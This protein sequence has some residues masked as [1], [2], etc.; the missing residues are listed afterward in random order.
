MASLPIRITV[1]QTAD[2]PWLNSNEPAIAARLDVT[3]HPAEDISKFQAALNESG[4]VTKLHSTNSN[5]YVVVDSESESFLLVNRI[6]HIP[7]VDGKG[8]H[9]HSYR[10]FDSN[11]PLQR[12]DA[13]FRDLHPNAEVG[14]RAENPA[15]MK[16]LQKLFHSLGYH[17]ND[18]VD[19]KL[20][21]LASPSNA[22][23]FQDVGAIKG[24]YDLTLKPLVADSGAELARDGNAKNPAYTQSPTE[25]ESYYK[26]FHA[27][28]M[29]SS[30]TMT[31]RFVIRG[32]YTPG[33][34][35]ALIITADA[36]L[37]ASPAIE[38]GEYAD[39]ALLALN[40]TARVATELIVTAGCAAE[41]AVEAAPLYL[42]P[43]VYAGAVVTGAAFCGSDMHH[44]LAIG[45][46]GLAII[47]ERVRDVADIK[48]LDP[49]HIWSSMLEKIKEGPATPIDPQ[50]A[51]ER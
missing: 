4:I 39:A 7:L 28:E 36:A 44:F 29:P 20:E 14:A 2:L 23:L 26:Q 50:Q 46:A 47:E 30:K 51:S 38:K 15:A 8:L 3:G 12:V 31:E 18:I 40:A 35:G 25:I 41:V 21:V 16:S 22:K 45:D 34:V 33:L 24:P 10:Q 5:I 42:S 27:D 6:K 49:D 37:A 11:T 17:G 13:L 19:G 32:R 1:K 9:V 48:G 43:P